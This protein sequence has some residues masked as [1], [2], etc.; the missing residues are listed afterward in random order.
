MTVAT[1]YAVAQFPSGEIFEGKVGT[2]AT[3]RLPQLIAGIDGVSVVVGRTKTAARAFSL[4]NAGGSSP[5]RIVVVKTPGG[6]K[7]KVVLKSSCPARLS[8]AVHPD[9]FRLATSLVHAELHP[10]KVSEFFIA[11]PE[12]DAV[13]VQGSVA[14]SDGAVATTSHE[15]VPIIAG[16][17]AA[18]G[19]ASLDEWINSAPR[20]SAQRLAADRL[21]ARK[22]LKE[23]VLGEVMLLSPAEV[24]ELAGSNAENPRP[25]AQRLREKGALALKEGKGFRYPAFQF[26]PNGTVPSEMRSILRLIHGGRD[27]RSV[28]DGWIAMEWFALPTGL[29]GDRR[30]MDVFVEDP[31]A[32]LTAAQR[33]FARYLREARDGD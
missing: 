3:D 31:E 11:Q 25:H 26:L 2:T 19:I 6:A 14:S 8:P 15:A 22:R 9:L 18:E 1:P 28:A 7:V 20:S 4:R 30:P 24:A 32:V 23:R 17:P 27:E 29:L 16:V 13:A 10:N 5:K 33:E 12:V 21:M